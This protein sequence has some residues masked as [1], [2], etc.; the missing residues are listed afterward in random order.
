MDGTYC[1]W[2]GG[3]CEHNNKP[4]CARQSVIK[5]RNLRDK[6]ESDKKDGDN[7]NLGKPS[8]GRG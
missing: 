2:V 6:Y 8:C 3:K 1:T 7:G 5:C 4:S